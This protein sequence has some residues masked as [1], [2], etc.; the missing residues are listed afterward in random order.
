[1]V[2]REF[3]GERAWSDELAALLVIEFRLRELQWQ[4]AG[5]DKAPRPEPP[6]PPET[7]DERRKNENKTLS[8]A[9]RFMRRQGTGGT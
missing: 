9:E 3:G 2:W 5:D 7:A 6:E 1:M 4:N 8:K